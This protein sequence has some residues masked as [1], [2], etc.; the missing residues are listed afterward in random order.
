MV[1]I[2]V[3]LYYQCSSLYVC[4]CNILW[5]WGYIFPWFASASQVVQNTGIQEGT[6]LLKSILFYSNVL[7][8]HSC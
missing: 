4:V 6:R 7:V 2:Y 5:K 1:H 8:L 3:F